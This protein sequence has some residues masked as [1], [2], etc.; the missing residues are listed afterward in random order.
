MARSTRRPPPTFLDGIVTLGVAVLGIWLLGRGIWDLFQGAASGL[1]TTV[2][3]VV[4]IG[5]GVARSVI[6]YRRNGRRRD[7]PSQRHRGPIL[8]VDQLAVELT[9]LTAREPGRWSL[10][11]ATADGFGAVGL[12][13]LEVVDAQEGRLR[14][15]GEGSGDFWIEIVGTELVGAW[16]ERPGRAQDRLPQVILAVS[17]GDYELVGE[18]LTVMVEG[19]RVSLRARM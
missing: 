10:T 2:M 19:K 4:A 6:L 5:V 7:A 15:W 8:T 1:V 14:V 9:P 13:V 3:G 11:R 16:W 12:D 18:R 17:R